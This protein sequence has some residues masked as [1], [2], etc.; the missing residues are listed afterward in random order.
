MYKKDSETNLSRERIK[1]A[2]AE[3]KNPQMHSGKQACMTSDL[4]MDE[5]EEAMKQLK[6][7]K[8]PGRDSVSNDMRKTLW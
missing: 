3:L 5:L 6:N 2:R 1:E 7:K 4:P 8:S